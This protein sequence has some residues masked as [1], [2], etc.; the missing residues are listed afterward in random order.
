M[1]A[2]VLDAFLRDID[3]RYRRADPGVRSALIYG[4]SARPS[5]E[6]EAKAAARRV[7]LQ[8][9]TE[10]QGLIDFSAYQSWQ[11]DRIEKDAV[12]PSALY[13]A[14]RAVLP[15]DSG[16]SETA[17]ALTELSR[18]LDSPLGRFILVLGDFGTGKTFLLRQLARRM[19]VERNAMVPVLIEMRAL[20][21]ASKLDVLIAQHCALAGIGA[22][23]SA[24]LSV[25]ALRRPDRAAVRWLR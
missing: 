25:H 16:E 3:A 18:L 7:L 8:S 21:K 12:Y 15:T 2:E 9:F 10:Y 5:P 11:R 1:D 20:E 4:D 6:V 22:D 17:D 13:V 14:Q 24:G 23:R 19:G